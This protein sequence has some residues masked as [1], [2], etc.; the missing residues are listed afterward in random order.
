MRLAKISFFREP[1][2]LTVA[3]I[4]A[5]TGAEPAADAPPDRAIADIASLE[6]AR[7]CDLTFLDGSKHLDAL[8]ATRAGACLMTGEFAAQAPKGVAVLRVKEPYRA[9]VAVARALHPDALRPSTLFDAEGAAPGA[10]VHPSAEIEDGVT[11]D[12]GAVIGPR[13][14]VGSGTVIGANAVIGPSVQ[15]GRGCAIG[16]NVS[17]V[18][19]LIGDGVIVQAGCHIGHDGFRY[20]SNA[21]GHV[22]VPQ[23]GRVIIQDHVEIGAGSTIDRGGGGDTVIGEGTKIDNLVQVGHNCTIGRHC[24][25]VSQCGISGSVTLADRVMLGGQVGIADHI[26]IGEGA[27]VAAKSGVISNIPAGEKW[28]GYPAMRRYDYLRIFAQMRRRP[29]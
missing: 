12:P 15:I 29:K 21:R 14:A 9:F 13:A 16:P 5:M 20:H 24:I 28:M 1:A 7:A 4:V 3:E 10:H 27:M 6:R 22:K 8:A 26:T 23:L 17:I 11:V 25:V 19:A 18:H 2:G